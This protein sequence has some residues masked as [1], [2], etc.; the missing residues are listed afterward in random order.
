MIR[1]ALLIATFASS[2]A[3]FACGDDTVG[4]GGAGGT[5]NG[6]AS[7][8]GGRGGSGGGGPVACGDTQGP[9][10]SDDESI[11]ALVGRPCNE[12]DATC[13]SDNGCGGC[14]VT[15]VD[16]VWQSTDDELCFNLATVAC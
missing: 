7:A 12:A 13:S 4:A 16:G 10:I 5:A 8:D 9:D 15:C 6:G 3:V 1:A 2:L 14:S 11:E